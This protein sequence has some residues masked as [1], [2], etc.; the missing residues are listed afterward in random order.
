MSMQTMVR[1]ERRSLI[2]GVVFAVLAIFTLLEIAVG[3]LP[4]LPRSI[5]LAVLIFLAVVKVA[6]VLLYFMHLKFDSRLFALPFALGIVLT[7]PLALIVG[8]TMNAKPS[9]AEPEGLIATGQV[10]DVKEVS[11]QIRM[12]QN[13]AQAGPVTFHVIN[14]ADDMLHE[15]I[16]V[17]TDAP[18]EELPTDM[19]GRVDED[20]VTII[21][22]AEDI[23]PANSRNL[24]V[25]LDAGH[26]VMICNLPGHY[27][28]GMRVDFTVT[29]T[30]N[31]LPSTPE[32]MPQPTGSPT[33]G[34]AMTPTS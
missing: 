13:T 28:Q 14:G 23:P 27:L 18:A 11:F 25:N 15:F 32:S 4:N 34:P 17:K 31:E 6:L 30:S 5:K 20:A 29:G 1:E 7:V 3:Y 9:N 8:F 21:T 26:Y 12:S 33:Q 16:I 10:I 22:A 24:T 19:M 2:F